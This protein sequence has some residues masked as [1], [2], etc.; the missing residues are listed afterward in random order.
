MSS[1]VRGKVRVGDLVQGTIKA[2]ARTDLRFNGAK[3]VDGTGQEVK[4][5]PLK[6]SATTTKK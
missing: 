3:L 4:T 6:E 5:R 1:M 2:G